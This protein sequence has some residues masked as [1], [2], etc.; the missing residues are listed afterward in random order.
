MIE[1]RGLNLAVSDHAQ[2]VPPDRLPGEFLKSL[3]TLALTDFFSIEKR[4]SL[5]ASAPLYRQGEVP[6]ELYV[7]LDGV[8]QMIS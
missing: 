1:N 3:G 6:S 4:I 2:F 5:P 8:P 7:L